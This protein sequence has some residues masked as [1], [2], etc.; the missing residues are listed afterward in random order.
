[1]VRRLEIFDDLGDADQVRVELGA[2]KLPHN[3]VGAGRDTLL[4]AGLL[5]A[6]LIRVVS[7]LAP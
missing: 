5:R 1:M 7:S 2:S 3:W 6:A 4:L